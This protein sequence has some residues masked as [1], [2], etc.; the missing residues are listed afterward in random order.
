[1]NAAASNP[2]YDAPKQKV[3]L[4]EEQA[5]YL[6]FKQKKLF[7]AD[8]AK[9]L[10]WEKHIEENMKIFA[11]APVSHQTIAKQMKELPEIKEK[12][13][14]SVKGRKILVIEIYNLGNVRRPMNLKYC[15]VNLPQIADTI[16]KQ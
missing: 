1:M 15:Y 7:R 4:G 5:K 2:T 14:L 13:I 8:S 11:R 16:S 10:K 3:N 9:V 12:D 6:S